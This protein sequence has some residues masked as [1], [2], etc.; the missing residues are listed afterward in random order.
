MS[1]FKDRILV[2]TP[3]SLSEGLSIL[4]SGLSHAFQNKTVLA[5]ALAPVLL[6][7]V[8]VSFFYSPLY[9]FIFSALEH[10]IISPENFLFWGGGVLLW[11]V[12]ILLKLVSAV[13][14]FLFF[15]IFLQIIYIPFC[16]L[17][18]ENILREKGII[19]ISGFSRLVAYNISML[20]VGLLKSLMLVCIGVVLFATSFVPILAFV[21]FYFAL[22]VL[23]YDSFDY[24]L[25]LYG[26]NLKQRSTFFQKEFF[27]LNGHVGVLFLLS[28]VPGLLLLTLPFSVVGASLKLGEVYEAKRQIT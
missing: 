5:L 2:Q 24:G 25:E 13:V 15:Y 28:F 16:S 18:A 14:S 11:L 17:L 9:T 8:C 12:T 10:K 20:K 23:A 3:K 19:K 1:R 7:F 27:M 26:L 21:P 4:S 6:A 22:L